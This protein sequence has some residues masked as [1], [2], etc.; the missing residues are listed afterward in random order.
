VS[1]A[2][3]SCLLGIPLLLLAA[4]IAGVHAEP[5]RSF[6]VTAEAAS[7]YAGNRKVH[8]AAGLIA[9]AL[10]VLGSHA[11]QDTFNLGLLLAALLGAAIMQARLLR[12]FWRVTLDYLNPRGWSPSG[13]PD[14]RWRYE[15]KCTF[16]EDPEYVDALFLRL[17]T[18]CPT[19]EELVA[20][21][22][23]GRFAGYDKVLDKRYWGPLFPTVRKLAALVLDEV[24]TNTGPYTPNRTPQQ[25]FSEM[26]A[27]SQGDRI[28]FMDRWQYYWCLR[29]LNYV[30]SLLKKTF[31]GPM[32]LSVLTAGTTIGLA[33]ALLGAGW[34]ADVVLR[35][36][37]AGALAWLVLACGGASLLLVS[38]FRG[39]GTFSIRYPSRGIHYDPLWTAITRLGILAFTLS[40]VVYGI[41]SPFVLM[42]DVLDHLRIETGFV[43]YSALSLT[44][45]LLVFLNHLVGTHML[46]V[47]SRDNALMRLD[48]HLER[49]TSATQRATCI[50]RYKEARGFG[51]W[52]IRGSTIA[53]LIAGIGFPI[54]VQAI[55]IYSGLKR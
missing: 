55:V 20:T 31:G 24:M 10:Y 43:V 40:F 47:G 53:T 21:V 35:F 48:R 36:E 26:R 15:M 41:G 54:A 5:R 1:I 17:F 37:L 25:I 50:E 42:P 52:P 39:T 32:Q 6:G 22:R 28:A 29:N 7:H 38:L 23:Q 30:Q 18:I 16:A 46:M 45:C 49:A 33:C 2:V 44:F 12:F 27:L 51:V 4:L 8:A 11:R 3:G 9:L 34:S 13:P 19:Y 14:T